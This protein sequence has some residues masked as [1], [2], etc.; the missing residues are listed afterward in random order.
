[1]KR[2]GARCGDA[3]FRL[4]EMRFLSFISR[5]E[6]ADGAILKIACGLGFGVQGG[7]DAVF[8]WTGGEKCEREGNV[9]F[10]LGICDGAFEWDAIIVLRG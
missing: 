6:R 8:F 1:M 3:C 10:G 7:G 4:A 5:R 2:F 9:P